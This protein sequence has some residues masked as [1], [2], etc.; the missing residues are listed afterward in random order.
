MKSTE[1]KYTPETLALA[2]HLNVDAD[3]ISETY[4]DP[5]LLESDDAPGEYLVLSEADAEK[6]ARK[7]IIESAWTFRSTFL[8]Y[9]TPDGI[10]ADMIDTMRGD[11]CDSFNEPILAII[12][13]GLG[14]D[15]FVQE[16][17]LS[18][19]RGPFL[20]SYDAEEY[21]RKIGDKWFYI[22]RVN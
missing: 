12:D 9:F 15:A 5:S 8:E 3:T 19:G 2:L 4:I 11:L 13:A 7:S 17:I 14:R 18:D 22:Y 21:E 16:A 1:S 6:A 10:T 20:A